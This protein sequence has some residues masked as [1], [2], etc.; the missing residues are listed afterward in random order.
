MNAT[1]MTVAR[2]AAIRAAKRNIH[3]ELLGLLRLSLHATIVRAATDYLRDPPK[4]V[5]EAEPWA[6]GR[7]FCSTRAGEYILVDKRT[8]VMSDTWLSTRNAP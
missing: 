5:D 8:G 3:R 2:L 4:L 7:N 6:G 1:I